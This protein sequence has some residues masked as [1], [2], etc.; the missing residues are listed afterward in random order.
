MILNH[1][2]KL[3]LD[4]ISRYGVEAQLK[5]VVEK[6]SK[7]IVALCHD[8]RGRAPKSGVIDELADVSIMLDQAMIIY[9]EED[10]RYAKAL[11]M[12]RL[13]ERLANG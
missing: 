5:M 2:R 8:N 6:C 4:A 9:G 3:F 1:E 7:L 11:K 12:K 10:V 13:Q